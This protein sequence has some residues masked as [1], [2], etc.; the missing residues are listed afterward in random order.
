[1][2]PPTD[3]EKPIP[4]LLE[5]TVNGA[6][7]ALDWLVEREGASLADLLRLAETA[8]AGGETPPL[9]I[10][11]GSRGARVLAVLESIAFLLQANLEELQLHGP[12]LTQLLVTGALSANDYLCQCL[13]RLSALLMTRAEVPE[14][15]ARGLARLVAG[16]AASDWS[17]AEAASQPPV[18]NRDR[19]QRYRQWRQ[20]LDQARR[21][22]QSPLRA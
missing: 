16:D 1:M 2:S 21:P 10:G 4:Y 6:G 3:F 20:A 11:G 14:A 19:D 17:V 7:S 12:P 15:T 18:L 13:G 9:F 5:G 22:S 8:R